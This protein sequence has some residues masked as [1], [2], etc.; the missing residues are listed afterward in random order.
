MVAL[1]LDNLQICLEINNLG[2]I[3]FMLTTF[4]KTMCI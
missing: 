1:D 2:M 3:E 4:S